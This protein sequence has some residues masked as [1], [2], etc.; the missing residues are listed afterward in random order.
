MPATQLQ[1]V[2]ARSDISLALQ[3]YSRESGNAV[4]FC[5]KTLGDFQVWTNKTHQREMFK[6]G[7]PDLQVLAPYEAG[8][9]FLWT[10]PLWPKCDAFEK[11]KK[12]RLNICVEN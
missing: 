7:A 6:P 1:K 5:K 11:K 2:A 12:K 9:K 4:L 3:H 8:C 10:L